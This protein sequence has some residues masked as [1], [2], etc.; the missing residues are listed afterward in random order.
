[1]TPGLEHR[2]TFLEIGR[3]LFLRPSGVSYDLLRLAEK[4]ADDYR[5]SAAFGRAPA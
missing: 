3:S 1:V 4:A 5:A 2:L